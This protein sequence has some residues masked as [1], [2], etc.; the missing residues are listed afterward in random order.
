MHRFLISLA[1]FVAGIGALASGPVLHQPDSFQHQQ[2]AAAVSN[3]AAA[4]R[5][6]T[7]VGALV[8]LDGSAPSP[9]G[10]P[11]RTRSVLLRL[12][13]IRTASTA[14]AAFLARISDSREYFSAHALARAGRLAFHTTAP[15][16]FRFV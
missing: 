6:S 16:P 12:E 5:T 9:R 11:R 15:P 4:L 14:A 13:G 8:W 2:L 7:T 1:L 3:D 10:M